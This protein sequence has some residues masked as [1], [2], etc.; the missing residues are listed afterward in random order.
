MTLLRAASYGKAFDPDID[1]APFVAAARSLRVLNNLR[2]F[3]VG[4]P[5]TAGERPPSPARACAVRIC[6][7]GEE[8]G[9]MQGSALRWK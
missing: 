1:A 4:M 5:L 3:T 9:V 8:G 7:A 2:Q 6:I